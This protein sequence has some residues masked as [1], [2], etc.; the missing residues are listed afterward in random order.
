MKTF[1]RATFLAARKAWA[2]GGFGPE[3][4]AVRRLA[5][6][7][8]FIYPPTG[9]RHDQRDDEEPSQRAIVYAAIEDTPRMLWVIIGRSSSWSQVVAQLIQLQ[10]RLAEDAGLA[11]DDVRLARRGEPTREQA[12][13]R[14]RDILRRL[15]P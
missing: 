2:E 1:D 12:A 5:A 13:E 9:D 8:G 15:E 7:R 4:R 3:W 6:E 11:E 10:G 14:L